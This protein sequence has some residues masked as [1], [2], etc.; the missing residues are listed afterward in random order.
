ML[1]DYYKI[2]RGRK[3]S[4]ANFQWIVEKHTGKAMDWFFKQWV[5]GTEILSYKYAYKIEKQEDQ[6]YIVAFRVKSE[7]VSEQFR[8]P[9]L[10]QFELENGAKLRVRKTIAGLYSE[11]SFKLP[12]QPKAVTFNYLNSVLCN[13]EE[14]S[15]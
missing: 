15:F 5:Y 10:I 3:A 2:F 11:F 6:K 13:V 14:K 1:Q 8:M 7:K 4:T 12:M 9:V